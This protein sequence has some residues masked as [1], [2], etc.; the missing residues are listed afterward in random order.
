MTWEPESNLEYISLRKPST[1]PQTTRLTPCRTASELVEEYYNTIGGRQFVHDAAQ[2]AKQPKKR[3]RASTGTTPAAKKSKKEP[4]P[5]SATP[6]ASLR[7]KEFK[8]PSG[9]WEEEVKA[10]DACEGTDGQVQVYL[11]WRNGHKTQH[12]LDMVYKRCP[13][14]VN[15]TKATVAPASVA[16]ETRRCANC[17]YIDAEVLRIPSVVLPYSKTHKGQD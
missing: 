15:Y 4:H 5:A 8:P 2:A 9:S 14:K 3:S 7:E 13:Q 10:I 12:P 6:P 17:E 16:M 11:T 1:P